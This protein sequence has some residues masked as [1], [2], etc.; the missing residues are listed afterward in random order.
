MTNKTKAEDGS[1]E[2]KDSDDISGLSIG[3][4][5]DHDG[6]N[7]SSSDGSRTAVPVSS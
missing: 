5:S 2:E 1:G 6:S 7:E 3:S 4:N